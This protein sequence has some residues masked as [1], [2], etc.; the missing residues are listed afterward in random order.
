MKNV[1]RHLLVMALCACG[2]SLHAQ[3][4]LTMY[5]RIDLGLGYQSDGTTPINAGNGRVGPAGEGWELKQG[6]AGRL[7]FR[8]TEDLG[9]G[10]SAN[11]TMEAR[12]DAGTGVAENPF[13]Q[14]RSFV[15]LA[16]KS[17]GA[18]YM[19]REY[20]PAFW[21]ALR[22]DPW[23]FDTVGTPGPK[24]QF[25]NYTVP[26]SGIRSDNTVGYKSPTFNG[27]SGILAYSLGETARSNSI[28]GNITYASGPVYIGAAFDHVDTNRKLAL[29]GGSYD[30]GVVRVGVT[31]SEATVAANSKNKNISLTGRIP[32]GPH[33]I[34]LGLYRLDLAGANNT[35]TRLGL[36]YEHALSKRTSLLAN[37][38]SAKQGSFTRSSLVDFTLKHNF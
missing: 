6:S 32:V 3:S 1:P 11:F 8:G 16:S 27:I 29:L 37:L 38:G 4:S 14:A 21:P 5:G 7:G 20:I 36:G 23:G 2:T 12:F 18:L 15:E 10:L 31:L 25:A 33:A 28:G 13:F 30:F 24:H 34:K 17:A 26:V 35:N 22:L 9:G 19:G